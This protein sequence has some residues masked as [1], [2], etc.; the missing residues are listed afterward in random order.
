[1]FAGSHVSDATVNY[2]ATD[3]LISLDNDFI[4]ESGECEA[5]SGF[6]IQLLTVK[7]S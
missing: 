1:M 7:F 6:F 3:E 2:L 4:C 5:V